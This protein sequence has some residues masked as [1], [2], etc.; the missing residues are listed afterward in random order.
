MKIHRFFS[1]EKLADKSSITITN[2][3]LLNQLKN[4]FRM[5][6]GD[7]IVLFDNTGFDFY[8]TVEGFENETVSLTISKV[9]ANN[10]LPMRETYLFV[11]LVKK[12]N[13]EWIVQKATELGVSHIIPIISERTEKKDIN[14]D[15]AKKIIIEAAEQSGRA[16]LPILMELIDL[17]GALQKYG[18]IKSIAWHTQSPKFSA[19]DIGDLLGSYIGPEGGWS[20]AEE[21]IFKKHGVPLRSLGPQVLR[22]ETAVIAVI[23]RLVF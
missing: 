22:S 21:D 4:V 15:R 2:E 8:A 1:E 6:K 19:Q 10:V 13:F 16:T 9:L 14:V 5:R 7:N 20:P 17:E 11:S 18:H 3:S 23:S 12:D